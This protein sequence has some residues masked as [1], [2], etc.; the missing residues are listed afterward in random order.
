MLNQTIPSV[1]QVKINFMKNED[2]IMAQ[3]SKASNR[4][5]RDGSVS[6]VGELVDGLNLQMLFSDGSAD[7]TQELKGVT[8][9]LRIR[10]EMF[11]TLNARFHELGNIGATVQ[12]TVDGNVEYGTL[13]ANGVEVESYTIY[14]ASVDL[15][16]EIAIQ[17]V[18]SRDDKAAVLNRMK[19]HKHANNAARETAI[20]SRRPQIQAAKAGAEQT[21]L[22]FG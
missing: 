3:G 11:E 22:N 16:E 12:V 21:A 1:A 19:A 14:V 2:K 8:V 20:A 18:G 13:V 17:R 15:V 6:L 4:V 9:N 10:P 5:M 7:M